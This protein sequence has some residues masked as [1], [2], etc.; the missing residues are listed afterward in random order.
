MPDLIAR[1]ESAIAAEIRAEL[2][3]QGLSQRELADRLGV[4]QWWV[5]RRA[6]G[7]QAITA[8][9]LVAVAL[10]LGVPVL[11]LLSAAVDLA[12]L[13]LAESEAAA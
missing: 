12:A 7:R 9:E 1:A 13:E 8:G 10:A 4:M 5:S 11:K 2:G 3:R 6:T